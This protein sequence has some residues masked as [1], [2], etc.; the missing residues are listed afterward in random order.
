MARA[1]YNYLADRRFELAPGRSLADESVRRQ[2]AGIPPKTIANISRDR[3]QRQHRC[4]EAGVDAVVNGGLVSA[5]EG[6]F[7]GR[8]CGRT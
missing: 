1:T 7:S 6:F 4:A 5:R 8:D 3:N 2:K